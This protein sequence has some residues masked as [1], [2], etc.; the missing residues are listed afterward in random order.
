M[1][2]VVNRNSPASKM[3]ELYHGSRRVIGSCAE[4]TLTKE[5]SRDIARS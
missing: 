5:K 3:R 1:A 4:G 2:A